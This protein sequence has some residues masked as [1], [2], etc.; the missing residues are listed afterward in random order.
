M[1]HGL[2]WPPTLDL[3]QAKKFRDDLDRAI[4]EAEA[5]AGG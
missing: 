1:P 4:E 3:A 2:F 5:I